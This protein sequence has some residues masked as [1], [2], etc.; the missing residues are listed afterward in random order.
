M[1]VAIMRTCY[2]EI[3]K[4]IG[5]NDEEKSNKI[6]NS[7]NLQMEVM[8]KIMTKFKKTSGNDEENVKKSQKSGNLQMEVKIMKKIRGEAE[9]MKPNPKM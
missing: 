7:G 1:E 4:K 8:V 9:N 6:K 5:P 2:D 3:S